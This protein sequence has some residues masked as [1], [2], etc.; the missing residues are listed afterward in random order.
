MYTLNRNLGLEWPDE[1][2]KY[3]N[4]ALGIPSRRIEENDTE[5]IPHSIPGAWMR[6][7]IGSIRLS[8]SNI[9]QLDLLRVDGKGTT[10]F[11]HLFIVRTNINR[12][13][14]DFDCC[15]QT[16]KFFSVSKS[17]NFIWKEGPLA[18]ELNLDLDLKA[19]L[20]PFKRY[21]KIE[22]DKEMHSVALLLDF[23]PHPDY[24]TQEQFQAMD[25]IAEHVLHFS[26]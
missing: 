17:I 25:R 16:E 23:S 9:H 19:T 18:E 3:L 2:S 22:A 26:I 15:W 12:N 6:K 10:M 7:R 13:I 14:K 21:I 24:L 20:A 4:G 1:Y 11:H 8:G 5:W